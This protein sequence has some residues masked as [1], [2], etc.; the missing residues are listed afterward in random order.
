MLFQNS[1]GFNGEC[2]MSQ[3]RHKK[4]P[5]NPRPEGMTR[6]YWRM[7]CRRYDG[8]KMPDPGYLLSEHREKLAAAWN[9][10]NP[11]LQQETAADY[12]YLGMVTRRT[13]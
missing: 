3:R 6:Q 7:L 1:L 12:A 10:T 4:H 2:L 11:T 8:G 9:K 13:D 5:N